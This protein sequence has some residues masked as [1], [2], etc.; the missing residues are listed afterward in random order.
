MG[1]GYAQK[2]PHLRNMEA[3]AY[4]LGNGFLVRDF[5]DS[6][7]MG[8]KLMKEWKENN[9]KVLNENQVRD[10]LELAGIAS[11]RPN[12]SAGGTM[13]GIFNVELIKTSINKS[14]K[15]VV[16]ITTENPLTGTGYSLSKKEKVKKIITITEPTLQKLID[17]GFKL[18]NF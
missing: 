1:E 8:D 6:A 17:K 4:L 14:G 3:E 16:K 13:Q 15:L 18:G 12:L 5:E 7:K 2:S 11:E 10:Y 9:K